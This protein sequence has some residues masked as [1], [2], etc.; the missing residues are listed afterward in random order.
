MRIDRGHGIQK[1]PR[2]RESRIV[3]SA[4][5]QASVTGPLMNDVCRLSFGHVSSCRGH[6][7]TLS[8][9]SVL[10]E[11]RQTHRSCGQ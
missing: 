5:G 10:I 4:A 8:D 7:T 6:Q 9:R 1:V 11:P 2:R 3:S